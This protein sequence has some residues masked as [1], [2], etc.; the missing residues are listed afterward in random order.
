MQLKDLKPGGLYQVKSANHFLR[1][2]EVEGIP[3]RPAG[4][5]ISRVY[6]RS[7]I[8]MYVESATYGSFENLAQFEFPK[9]L[10][11]FHFLVGESS[12]WFTIESLLDLVPLS[13]PG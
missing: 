2:V 10:Y 6:N 4:T 12:L 13:Q 9:D 8:F 3:R 1:C 5:E 7:D 11:L